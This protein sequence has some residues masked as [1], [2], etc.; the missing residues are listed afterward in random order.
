MNLLSAALIS[1]QPRAMLSLPGLL[2]AMARD[3]VRGFPA[4]RPHQ[5]AA[6][7][8]FLVQLGALALFRAGRTNL[9]V[10][11]DDW[12]ILLLAL[13]GGPEAWDL[14]APDARPGFMQPPAP[15]GL[16]WTPVDTPDALDLLITSRNHDLKQRVAQ[17]CDPQ[18]WLFA[19][20]SLQTSEGYGGAGN[21]GIA[22]MNGG[23]S[24]RAMLAFAPD[25]Q[26]RGVIDPSQWWRRDVLTLLRLRSQGREIAPGRPGGPA[27]L[28]TLPWPEGVQLDLTALDPWC[29]EVCRRIR[30]VRKDGKIVALRATSKAARIDAKAFSGVTGDPWAPITAGESQKSLTLGEGNFTYRRLN[31]LLF[32]RHWHPSPLADPHEDEGDGLLLAE[33]LSRGN[34]KTDGLKSRVIPV[35]GRVLSFLFQESTAQMANEQIEEIGAFDTALKFGLATFAA[36]GAATVPLS[37]Y[38]RS[39]PARA[40]FDAQADTMFFSALFDR[41]QAD[42]E[43]GLAGKEQARIRF[44][45]A[46]LNRA[47]LEFAAALPSIPVSAIRRP[48]ARAR[49]ERAF[50]RSLRRAPFASLIGLGSREDVDAT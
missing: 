27:L 19:L 31:D 3:E 49:A 5:R 14:F 42:A 40:A 48:R 47:R 39:N 35:P 41:V 34:S 38:A 2:A 9:P 21:H 23:S 15:A 10:T 26:G 8:C 32:S 33:A 16:K 44:L 25:P 36:D 30:L 22:R 29:I 1:A 4:L 37:A 13:S 24:S 43:A 28:W 18:D 17:D 46:L 12:R 7:H 6:W 20:V 11:D 45:K 50:D